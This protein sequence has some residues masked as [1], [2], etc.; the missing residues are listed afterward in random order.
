[1]CGRNLSRLVA[2]NTGASASR[3]F[4]NSVCHAYLLVRKPGNVLFYSTGREAIGKVNEDR[5]DHDRMEELGGV[6]HM[7]LCHWHEASRSVRMIKERFAATILSHARDAPPIERESG[8]APDT[9]ILGPSDAPWRCRGGTPTPGREVRRRLL[10]IPFPARQKLSLH[11][12]YDL[13]GARELDFG[14]VRRRCE[15]V[16]ASTRAWTCWRRWSPMWCSRLSPPV[17]R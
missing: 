14:H 1:M 7:F 8:V 13:A 2:D 12:R 10:P 6:G 5:T 11:G 9:D 17:T 4:P 15:A 3:A 16:V